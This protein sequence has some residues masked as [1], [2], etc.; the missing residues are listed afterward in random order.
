MWVCGLRGK[1]KWDEWQ[2]LCSP[3][4]RNKQYFVPQKHVLSFS[5]FH[6]STAYGAEKTSKKTQ[7]LQAFW[8][9]G[10]TKC[11]D[12]SRK[13]ETRQQCLYPPTHPAPSAQWLLKLRR[14][15]LLPDW[16]LFR[17]LSSFFSPLGCFWPQARIL[18]PALLVFQSL[19]F[20]QSSQRIVVQPVPSVPFAF[21]TIKF[22]QSQG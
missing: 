22:D 6:R 15:S 13:E 17:E 4:V 18:A 11:S 21:F 5:P 19:F 7:E 9:G 12:D 3:R 16:S 1:A 14:H 2:T 8:Q 20:L 10:G